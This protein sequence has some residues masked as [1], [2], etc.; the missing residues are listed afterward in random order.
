MTTGMSAPPIPTTRP[1]PSTSATTVNTK[2]SGRSPP[3]AEAENAA[4]QSR[5]R[6]ATASTMFSHWA[7][8][9]PTRLFQSLPASLA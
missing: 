2:A 9:G 3:P 4:S 8:S 1:I 6:Q 5:A 7:P